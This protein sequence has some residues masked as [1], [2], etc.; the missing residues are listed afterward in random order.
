MKERE[1]KEKNVRN[2]GGGTEGEREGKKKETMLP[3]F[4]YF[5]ESGNQ[6]RKVAPA[7][8]LYKLKGN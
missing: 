8:S 1:S 5:I 6:R 4:Y 3:L 7:L 2:H